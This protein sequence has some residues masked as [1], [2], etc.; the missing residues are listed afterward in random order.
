MN[1]GRF[2][3]ITSIEDMLGWQK[4]SFNTAFK[5]N[6][7]GISEYTMAQIQAKDK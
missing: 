1:S 6:D 7:S 5:I 2:K 4:D 3:G